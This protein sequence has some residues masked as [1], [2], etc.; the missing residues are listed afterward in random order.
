[1]V[2]G[3]SLF[4]CIL[5]YHKFFLFSELVKVIFLIKKFFRIKSLDFLFDKLDCKKLF[6]VCNYCNTNKLLVKTSPVISILNVSPQCI[7]GRTNDSETL[8]KACC[9]TFHTIIHIF[10]LYSEL[11]G[12]EYI[13]GWRGWDVSSW[14][15]MIY[16][17]ACQTAMVHPFW[18]HGFQLKKKDNPVW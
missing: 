18:N 10:W 7:P 11:L 4:F 8:D 14:I 3:E 13:A 2:L 6:L 15:H 1:M 12:R 16:F 5:I 17:E 9:N